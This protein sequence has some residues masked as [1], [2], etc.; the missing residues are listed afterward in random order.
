M[1][2]VAADTPA[3]AEGTGGAKVWSGRRKSLAVTLQLGLI[4]LRPSGTV[5]GSELSEVS[6]GMRNQKKYNKQIPCHAV[7]SVADICI[8]CGIARTFASFDS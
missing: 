7:G 8:L 2:D 5:P 6:G 1:V 4:G 3:A